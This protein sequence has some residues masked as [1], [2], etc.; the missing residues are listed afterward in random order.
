MNSRPSLF[1]VPMVRAILE[2]RKTQTRRVIKEADNGVTTTM[3]DGTP[4]Y[5]DEAG[6]WNE[7]SSPYGEKGDQL[8]VREAWCYPATSRKNPRLDYPLRDIEYRADVGIMR[9]PLGGNYAVQDRDFKWKPSIHM[10]RSDSRITLEITDIRFERLN[11]ISE[12][13]AVAEGIVY[14]PYWKSSKYEGGTI[15]EN[16]VTAFSEL[17]E[18]INGVGS[19]NANPWVWVV[20]FKKVKP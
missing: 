4:Y 5:C 17:W 11:S 9:Y 15:C 7:R 16:A 6:N 3:E 14:D 20:E 12:S 18:S 2:G 1:S 8:W 10:R 19:W 13:D